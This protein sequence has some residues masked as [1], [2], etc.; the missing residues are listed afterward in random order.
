VK[1]FSDKK[2]VALSAR[3]LILTS[4]LS[5]IIPFMMGSSQFLLVNVSMMWWIYCCNLYI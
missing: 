2:H 5:I 4:L 1:S 3:K